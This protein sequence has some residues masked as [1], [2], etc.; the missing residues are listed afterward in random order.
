MLYNKATVVVHAD[1]R[2]I[3]LFIVL[4]HDVGNGFG[5]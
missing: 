5:D 4:L 2:L 1:S 3:R